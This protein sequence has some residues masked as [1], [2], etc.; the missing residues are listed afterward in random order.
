MGKVYVV[1][2][3]TADIPKELAQSLGI[4]VV[5]LKVHMQN[6]TYLDGETITPNVFYEKLKQSDELPTTSQPSPMD[7]VKTY[8]K[9]ANGNEAKIISIHLSAA[10]SGTVQSALL[11]RSM[12]EEEGIEVAVLDS[13]KASYSIGI[14]VVGVAEAVKA[15]KSFEEA[16]QIAEELIKDTQVYFLVDSLTYL[17][18]GGRI[19][20]ASS[21]FGSLL[22]IKP[23]LS[24]NDQGEVFAIDKVRGRNK[25]TAKIIEMLMDYAKDQKV[26]VGISHAINLEEAQKL[27]QLVREKMN[28]QDFVITE[29]GPVI[30]THVGPGTLA[31]MMYKS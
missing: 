18:K 25:A 3:S 26:R 14:I 22:N 2:D 13:K 11:A 31:I 5:P 12:V 29:I 4:T 28:V 23:I 7:F 1:T 9:L 16:I 6:Q 20:R 24:L 19:G 21:L 10:L 30:G 27:E 15:G 8:Q 17:H